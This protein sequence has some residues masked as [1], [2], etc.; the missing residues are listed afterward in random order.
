MFLCINNINYWTAPL[1]IMVEYY[2]KT[3]IS[4]FHRKQTQ[5][6]NINY[7]MIP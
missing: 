7:V 1:Q 4:H 6:V 2:S 3:N 5:I